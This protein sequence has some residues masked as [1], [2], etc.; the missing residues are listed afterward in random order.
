MELIKELGTKF[1]YGR[2]N[3]VGLFLCPVC[4]KEVERYLHNG[5]RYKSC[6]CHPSKRIWTEKQKK[7][8]SE[9]YKGSGNPMFGKTMNEELK[10]KI[11]IANKGR[12]NSEESLKKMSEARKGKPCP[13]ITRQKLTG[14]HP[15]QKTIEKLIKSHLGKKL[16]KEA[17]KKL[18]ERKGAKCSFWKGGITPLTKKIR[19]SFEYRK[20]KQEV[21]N[22]DNFTCQS[23]K[24][25]GG[26]LEAHHVKAFS[27]L[28]QEAKDNIPLF[29][30]FEASMMYKPMWDINNGITLCKICHSKTK[31][32]KGKSK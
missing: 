2:N 3:S 27:E 21:F 26:Y 14:R 30:L 25:R 29:N 7:E 15:N 22:R 8:L 32:Y 20:W 4:K 18:R 24:K 16:S 5:L 28:I 31:N 10:N 9:K 19:H 6:G 23:C 13:E 1:I 12:K 17:I 11:F